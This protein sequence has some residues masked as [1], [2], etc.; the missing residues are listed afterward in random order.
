M[1]RVVVWEQK[2]IIIKTEPRPA[3]QI[4]EA[5]VGN[6]DN[7]GVIGESGEGPIAATG[8]RAPVRLAGKGQISMTSSAW[9]MSYPFPSPDNAGQME[10]QFMPTF[11]LFLCST[12]S[13]H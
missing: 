5:V 11:I 1:N 13:L 4:W 6:V 8:G 12:P 7:S 3:V 2:E 10:P 9:S